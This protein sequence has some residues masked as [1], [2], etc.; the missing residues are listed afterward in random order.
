LVVDVDDAWL[1]RATRTPEHLDIVRRLGP[2]SIIVAP[3]SARG[4]TLGVMSFVMADSTRRYAP[5]DVSLA[6]DL[7][8]RA[9]AAVDNARLYRQSESAREDAEAAS[10]AKGQ[11]LAVMSHELRT[12][13]NAISG[14]TE[15][16][17]M[18]I[19]GPVTPA[20]RDDLERIH[21][22][23]RHL[24]G[25]INNLL[26]Y[27]KI[28][29]GGVRAVSENVSLCDVI[30]AAITMVSPQ[31][32]AKE[33][34]C[35]YT[36]PE[37]LQVLADRDKVEQI[38]LNLLANAVKFTPRDGRITITGDTAGTHVELAIADSGPGVPTAMRER[39][40]EPFVQLGTPV[41]SHT[42]GTGLGLAISRD[43]ARLM[44]GGMRIEEAEGGGARFVLSLPAS[45]DA[46]TGPV[47]TRTF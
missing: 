13:L 26:D 37:R 22:S 44:N 47:V 24:L 16:M 28:E 36:V 18:E 46:D 34:H 8:H 43:L 7:A 23:Q 20:Q 5:G 35:S 31:I 41:T 9:A 32:H 17:L 25:I 33:L 45:P 6:V 3:L 19:H 10:R 11:F 38:V 21:R 14:Y 1:Q 42:G 15:L 27:A 40:F 30:E 2:R 12:P 4:H 39:V 29:G